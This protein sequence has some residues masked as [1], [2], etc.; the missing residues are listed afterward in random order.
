MK[1][2]LVKPYD[3]IVVFVLGCIGFLTGCSIINPP[4]AE[5]GVPHADYE[6]KGL[7]TD[8]IS[9][10]PIKNS[11]IIVT[12][13]QVYTEK[14]STFTHIDTLSTKVTDNDGKYDIQFQDFPF[15]ENV[16]HLKIDDID[17]IDNG[18]EFRSQEKDVSFL[19][20]DLSGKRGWY[21]GK[22]VKVVNI[23]L[24]IKTK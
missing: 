13:T 7:I 4:I 10:T 6:I 5:Y 16:Y 1:K 11:R 23:K 9:S 19:L 20:S 21:D 18:G 24:Q 2:L 22:A 14:D 12:R 3:K 17:G 8:S 15:E